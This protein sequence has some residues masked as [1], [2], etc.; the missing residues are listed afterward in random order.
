VVSGIEA[1]TTTIAEQNKK[2]EVLV[3]DNTVLRNEI[4]NLSQDLKLSKR[5]L[6]RVEHTVSKM[7]AELKGRFDRMLEKSENNRMQGAIDRLLEE[8]GRVRGNPLTSVPA[9]GG[10]T[11]LPSHTPYA[12]DLAACGGGW[13]SSDEYGL[14]EPS[15]PNYQENWEQPVRLAR[16]LS[17]TEFYF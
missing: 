14:A 2:I 17:Q 1:L 12:P 4:R 16:H 7:T 13:S 15:R 3:Q 10:V 6:L 11:P 5:D 9:P 8:L